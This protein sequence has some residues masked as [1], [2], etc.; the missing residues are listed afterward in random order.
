MNEEM[1]KAEEILKE[2]DEKRKKIIE[3]REL[4]D[5]QIEK[6]NHK[7]SVLYSC[8]QMLTTLKNVFPDGYKKLI[9]DL[10]KS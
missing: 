1:N 5:S 2:F 3:E 4:E 8:L 10:T 7:Y 6:E 9:S